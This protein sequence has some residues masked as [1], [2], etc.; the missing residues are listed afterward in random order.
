ME[1]KRTALYEEHVKLNG[2]I[3]DFHGWDM[4]LQYTR[5]LEEH[6]AVRKNV[7]IFDV[8]HMGDVIVEGKEAAA[9][10]DHMFPTKISSI[11]NGEATYTAF[12]DSKGK[13]IDDTIVYRIS[14]NKFFFVPNASMIDII[15][16][17]ILENKGKFD[18]KITNVSDDISC[19]AVQGPK[20]E[21]VI[22]ELGLVF[23]EPF[24]FIEINGK[25]GKN[26]ITGNNSVIVSGTGYTGEKGVELLIPSTNAA[27]MWEKALKLIG[28]K[29]GLPCGLGARDTLRMEKGML[30]SGTDFN[31]DRNPY[32]CSISFIV[33]NDSDYIGKKSIEDKGN[34]IF[35]G[36][37]LNGKLIPRA[38]SEVFMD[39]K[40]IGT[41]TSGTL[42]PMLNTAIALGFVNR[43]YMKSGQDVDI[44]IRGRME[45][46]S[47]G[48]PKI[49]P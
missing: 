15:Y 22:N 40:K 32:E 2:K 28:K 27:E 37:K 13:I 1:N 3:I 48:K 38:G 19:I 45:K 25:F 35:R 6:M 30:L 24:K 36:F 31:R 12:L 29:S 5:I 44:S 8:S 46:G 23:P 7:G 47:M 20:S 49:V 33:N 26:K 4:P 10:L 17:W 11:K 16:N 42:S 34:E 43:S 14:E 21:E 39:G 41:I 18:V 9:F